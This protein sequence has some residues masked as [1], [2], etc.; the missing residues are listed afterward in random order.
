MTMG[1]VGDTDFLPRGH[2]GDMAFGLIWVQ[3]PGKPENSRSG[4]KVRILGR[5]QTPQN[6]YNSV[7]QVFA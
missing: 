2:L 6:A 1:H 7:Q 5:F 3:G 4:P